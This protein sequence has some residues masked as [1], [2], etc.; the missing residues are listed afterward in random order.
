MSALD[1][2]PGRMA[3]AADDRR[4][5]RAARRAFTLVE[6]MISLTLAGLL[7]TAVFS[8]Y[9]YIL[10]SYASIESYAK[11]NAEARTFVGY[12]GRDLRAAKAVSNFTA[13]NLIFTV[14]TDISGGTA[15]VSYTFVPANGTVIRTE[16]SVSTTVLHNIESFSFAYFNRISVATAVLAELKQVR[17]NFTLV[18]YVSAVRLSQQVISAQ[19]VLRAAD[20]S[21]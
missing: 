12:L 16:N 10:R 2:N 17:V 9:I 8:S 5:W 15:T 1:F 21:S 6:M 4:R 20:V 19:Y 7:I 3:R 11:L 14:P 18:E 13:T